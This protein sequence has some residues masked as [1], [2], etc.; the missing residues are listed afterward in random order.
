[1]SNASYTMFTAVIQFCCTMC[2]DVFVFK[3]V[4]IYVGMSGYAE[5][6]WVGA[7]EKLVS[8]QGVTTNAQK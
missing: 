3:L 6:I 1:M 5:T 7:H 2:H 8:A 4:S